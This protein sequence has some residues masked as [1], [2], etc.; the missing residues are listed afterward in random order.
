L[1]AAIC[2]IPAPIAPVPM[3]PTVNFILK[4]LCFK[5]AKLFEVLDTIQSKIVLSNIAVVYTLSIFILAVA[6]V[7]NKSHNFVF[8]NYEINTRFFPLP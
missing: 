2:A 6:I 3:I 7:L 8:L 1:L 5:S 4:Y